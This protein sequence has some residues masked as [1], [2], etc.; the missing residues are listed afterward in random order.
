MKL[1]F[2]V[3]IVTAITLVTPIW[4][5]GR[6][7]TTWTTGILSTRLDEPTGAIFD[8]LTIEYSSGELTATCIFANMESSKY[9]PVEVIIEGEWRDGLFWPAV[10]EQVGDL[11]AGPWY[12]IPMVARPE[13]L[14]KV[15]V[16]PGQERKLRFRLN[17]LL[18]YI[19]SFKVG[20]IVLTSGDFAVMELVNLK[21]KS[22]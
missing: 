14:A 13:K 3:A 5:V 12:S 22:H 17:D 7:E 9:R 21:G 18:P 10:K 11:Y 15:A 19:G 20:R 8:V 16:S 4:S 6:G 1:K 2:G